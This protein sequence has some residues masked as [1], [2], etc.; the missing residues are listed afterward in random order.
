MNRITQKFDE[1]RADNRTAFIGY[2]T[3]GD[4]SLEATSE[5]VLAIEAGGADI[6]EIG[7]PYSDPLADGPVIQAAGLRAFDA[8]IRVADVFDIAQKV[9]ESSQI[10]LLFMVYYNT[11][12]NMGNEEFVSKCKGVGI[13]GIIVPDLPLEEREELLQYTDPMDICLIPL[14]APTSS[15]RIVQISEGASG[16]VY[17][18]STMGVTGMRLGHDDTVVEYLQEVMAKSSLPVAVGFGIGSSEAVEFYSQYVDGVIVGSA[19]VNKIHETKA[20]T[21]EISD[22]IRQLKGE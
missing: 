15:D 8:G 9:R 7:I 13:D 2:V 17:C 20:D 19:I 18:V 16:F 12:F 11:I 21:R 14:V 5:L 3:A 10:P 1:L 4:P 22:F 6:V